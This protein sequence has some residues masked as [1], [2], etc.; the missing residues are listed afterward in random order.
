MNNNKDDLYI[1]LLIRT[2]ACVSIIVMGLAII[3]FEQHPCWYYIICNRLTSLNCTLCDR[4]QVVQIMSNYN[5]CHGPE[6]HTKQTQN[7]IRGV[8]G[9]KVLRTRKIIK[10]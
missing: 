6:C 9:K 10:K 8:K 3:I 2:I 5:W 1:W 7:R 4:Q